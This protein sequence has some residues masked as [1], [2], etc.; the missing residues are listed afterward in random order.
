MTCRF[1]ESFDY[2]TSNIEL[3]RKWTSLTNGAFVTVGSA[4]VRTGANSLLLASSLGIVDLTLDDQASWVI[5][6]G[7]Y[8]TN[9][10]LLS[11]FLE[12]RDDGTVQCS[13]RVN[14]DGTLEVVQGTATIV[15]GGRST[16]TL[17]ANTWYYIEMKV[18]I[19][20]SIGAN[21]CKVRVNEADWLTVATGQDLKVSANATA[22]QFRLRSGASFD[23]YFDDIYIF[24]GTGSDNNDFAGDVKVV[25]L[26]PDGDGATNDFTRSAGANNFELVD[27]PDTD[28]DT[29]YVESDTATD[30]DLYTFDDLA[31]SV[32]TVHAVGVN[33]VAKKDD[34]GSRTMRA[35]TRPVVT[36]KFGDIESPSNG[37]YLNFTKIYDLNPETAAAWTPTLLNATEFGVEIQA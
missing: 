6:L 22:N 25:A 36:N 30:I 12:I 4:Q 5:G 32:T 27:D 15:T 13:L 18:T 23:H 7:I 33:F 8:F 20:D 28:D 31:A 26:F 11:R 21:T 19:A 35:V 1:L 16:L 34:S 3:T 37:S 17:T 9:V 29:S 24:D 2:Y 10:S 14:A